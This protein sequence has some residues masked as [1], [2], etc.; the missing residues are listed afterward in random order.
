LPGFLKGEYQ[1]RDN[2]ER[3]DLA[4]VCSAKKLYHAS[5]RLYAAAFAAD[6]ILSDDLQTGHRYN[7]ACFAA[8][9]A[10]GQGE[11]AAKLDDKERARLR[12]QA[13]DWVRADLALWTKKLESNQPA[14]RATVQSTVEYWRQDPDLAGLRDEA[15]LAKLPEDER[16]AWQ[17]LWREVEALL[18]RAEKP[19]P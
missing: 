18:E 12:Q 10:A 2:T 13:L 8:L 14:D 5:A 4:S 11:D 15:P 1:A 7:A 17:A 19:T 16:K 9:A 3:L 6:P